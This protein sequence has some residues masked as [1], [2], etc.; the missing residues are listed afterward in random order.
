MANAVVID[1]SFT[2]HEYAT[3]DRLSSS[4]VKVEKGGM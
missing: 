1:G 2:I 4:Y 3:A